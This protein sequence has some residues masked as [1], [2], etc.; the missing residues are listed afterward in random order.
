[1][2]RLITL[3][4]LVA[5]AL[6]AC[7]PAVTPA[8]TVEP[9]PDVEA[10]ARVVAEEVFSQVS[11]PEPERIVTM[12]GEDAP[13]VFM[14][15]A[16]V[17]DQIRDAGGSSWGLL[18]GETLMVGFEVPNDKLSDD[19]GVVY[20][21][22]RAVL[23]LMRFAGVGTE[24]PGSAR[25]GLQVGGDDYLGTCS[26]GKTPQGEWAIVFDVQV[27]FDRAERVRGQA[28]TNDFPTHFHY[29]PYGN[30]IIPIP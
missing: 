28:D 12:F 10:T 2:K 22:P 18:R 21:V 19:V 17:D 7:G 16:R 24:L 8:P 1:M 25:I 20:V 9:T 26:W 3:V 4:A 11:T 27:A 13:A 30:C 14:K 5:V 29:G 23:P 6:A 15:D